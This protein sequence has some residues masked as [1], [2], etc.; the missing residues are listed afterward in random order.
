MCWF[1]ECESKH[2]PFDKQ[3]QLRAEYRQYSHSI[4]RECHQYVSAEEHPAEKQHTALRFSGAASVGIRCP[5][6]YEATIA[7]CFLVKMHGGLSRSRVFA[8]HV[9]TQYSPHGDPGPEPIIRKEEYATCLAVPHT[10]TRATTKRCICSSAT[11]ASTI[12]WDSLACPGVVAWRAMR[13]RAAFGYCHKIAI[14]EPLTLSASE[15]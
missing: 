13:F 5:E 4:L 1:K 15:R 7:S 12:S 6:F 8:W 10:G 11:Q 14:Q 3:V 2:S 9:K